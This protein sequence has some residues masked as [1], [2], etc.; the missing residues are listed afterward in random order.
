MSVNNTMVSDYEENRVYALSAV[1]LFIVSVVFAVFYLFGHFANLPAGSSIM[2]D[3]LWNFVIPLLL[4]APASFF[5]TYEILTGKKE[6]PIAFHVKRFLVRMAILFITLLLL[7]L[8]YVSSY[9]LLA[10]LISERFALLSGFLLWLAILIL[11]IAR[12]KVF[13]GRLEKGKW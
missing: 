1:P 5:L 13:F 9:F 8:V 10:P 4:L 7:I 2:W 3:L 6:Q 12:F 11:G